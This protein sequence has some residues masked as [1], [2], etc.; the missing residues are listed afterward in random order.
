MQFYRNAKI[1]QKFKKKIRSHTFLKKQLVEGKAISSHTKFHG[2]SI[3]WLR[4]IT[5]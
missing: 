5:C 2:E 1:V 3:E 4:V